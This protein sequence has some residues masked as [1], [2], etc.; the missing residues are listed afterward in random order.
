MTRVRTRCFTD[1]PFRTKSVRQ[2]VQQFRVCR[3]ISQVPE[4]VGRGDDAAAEHPLPDPVDEHAR[5]QRILGAG[6]QISQLQP[7]AALGAA[8]VVRPQDPNVSPGNQVSQV[9]VNSPDIDAIV[10]ARVQIDHA[11]DGLGFQKPLLHGAVGGDQISNRLP[12]LQAVGQQL[13]AEHPVDQPDVIFVRAIIGPVLE[14]SGQPRAITRSSLRQA[15]RRIAGE[16]KL[17]PGELVR[18]R[19]DAIEDGAVVRDLA[20]IDQVRPGDAEPALRVLGPAVVLRD[21]FISATAQPV[22]WR[23]VGVGGLGGE[24][25]IVPGFRRFDG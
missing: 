11:V 20:F 22:T 5:S 3:L 10:A 16:E 4:I 19:L 17:E 12:L 2:V 18:R 24:L 1:Q 14:G 6:H 25:E 23:E 7:S 21:F 9:V 15:G 8:V 13:P